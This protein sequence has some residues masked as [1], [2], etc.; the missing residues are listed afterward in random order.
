MQLNSLKDLYI[1]Q[2]RDL[3]SAED[4]LIKALPEMA[5]AASHDELRKGF[6]EHLEQTRQ[7]KQRLEE[8]FSSLGERPGGEHCE[9]MEGLVKEG[10]EILQMQ[11]DASVK[12]AALIAA[13]QRVEHYEIAGYG[14]VATFAEM[15]GRGDDKTTLGKTLE[16]EKKTDDK[17][18]KLAKQVV[19][20]DALQQA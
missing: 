8:V 17:L 9:A 5:R 13:A 11:G 4:Q 2:L 6:E 19:N 15:L 10:K 12:D 18:T 3:Y 7:H 16:E 14:T 1:E 20:R